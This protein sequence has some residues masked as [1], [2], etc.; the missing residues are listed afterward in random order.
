[1]SSNTCA[2]ALAGLLAAAP[3]AVAAQHAEAPRRPAS[4]PTSV[5][6]VPAYASAFE[7][8]RPLK[9]QPVTSWREANELVRRIGG[10]Q[11]Y[12]REAQGGASAASGARPAA[13]GATGGHAG[14]AKP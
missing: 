6:P 12:A 4:A 3:F 10:W 8:Y 9:D 13:S 5:V 1:M 7:G 2:A 11:A 14:H